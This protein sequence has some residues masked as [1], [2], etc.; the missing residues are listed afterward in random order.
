[1]IHLQKIHHRSA[2]GLGAYSTLTYLQ[3]DRQSHTQTEFYNIRLLFKSKIRTLFLSNLGADWL[4][5]NF[6]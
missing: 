1:M 2:H 5:L 3:I 6:D 4:T